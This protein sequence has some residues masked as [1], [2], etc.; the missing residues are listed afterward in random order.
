[1]AVLGAIYAFGLM[2]AGFADDDE[3]DYSKQAL[4][5]IFERTTNETTSSQLGLIKETYSTIKE[6]FVGINQ[7][8]E[9]PQ[10]YKLVT[11]DELVKS[12]R[13][14]G[15]SQRERWLIKNIVGAKP[16][17]DLMNAKNL[18]SQRDSY[19][20]FASE[21]DSFNPFTWIITKKEYLEDTEEE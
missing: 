1:M 4:A 18:K 20:H 9:I 16:A 17:Y 11:G 14:H 21:T 8:L 10:V 15:L 13:Y 3:D 5:Y 7:L 12:G 6:P 19:N 2:F